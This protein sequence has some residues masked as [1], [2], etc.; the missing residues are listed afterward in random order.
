MKTIQRNIPPACLERQPV[1]QPWEAFA[2]T[3][4]H[5]ELL[6]GLI[7]EQSG[8][9]C[10]C[11][12]QIS[13]CDGHIEH[14]EPRSRNQNRTYDY[15]NLA[16]SCN[17]GKGEHCG[18]FKDNRHRNPHYCWDSCNFSSPHDSQTTLLFDYNNSLGH[19]TPT[20]VN[21]DKAE[22]MIGYLGLNSARL[23]ERRHSHASKL[24]TILGEQ[25]D[26]S[27]KSW[28]V[29]EFLKPDIAGNLK[30]FY[31]LSKALLKQ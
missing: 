3:L 27:L 26:Q 5:T 14:M 31:S 24:I 9:C 1:T 8:L 4:C 22:Y 10:Y 21:P 28:L 30:P 17:G 12:S 15:S 2:G 25:P 6:L 7:H 20:T 13:D 29:E 18:H 19:V 11:E 16:S 23:V